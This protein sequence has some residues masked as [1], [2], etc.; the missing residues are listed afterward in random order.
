MPVQCHVFAQRNPAVENSYRG[1][2]NLSDQIDIGEFDINGI[3][4][5]VG[6]A[7][8]VEVVVFP[9][10]GEGVAA[11]VYLEVAA[12]VYGRVVVATSRGYRD[13]GAQRD[14]CRGVG[15]GAARLQG[16]EQGVVCG[17]GDTFRHGLRYRI[18]LAARSKDYCCT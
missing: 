1:V 6:I 15:R 4:V 18:V 3:G 10:P 5:G 16:V 9:F 8:E 11:A 12:T 17:D 7:E 13:V 2:H 14:E